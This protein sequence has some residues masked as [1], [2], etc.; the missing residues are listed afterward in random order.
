MYL[1]RDFLPCS[2]S[3]CA[4]LVVHRSPPLPFLGPPPSS[5]RPSSGLAR[6]AVLVPTE[7]GHH[8]E[9]QHDDTE[10]PEATAVV[11][12]R[13]PERRPR[14]EE[15]AHERPEPAHEGRSQVV[16]D[17]PEDEEHEPRADAQQGQNEEPHST[18][19]CSMRRMATV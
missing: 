6:G 10:E 12:V 2:L 19:P 4:D 3:R 7:V 9:H 15:E 18:L 1:V 13:A 16:T 14:H 17:Y 5:A 11:D 8:T